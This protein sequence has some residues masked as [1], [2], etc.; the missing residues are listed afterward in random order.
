MPYAF[1]KI[2]PENLVLLQV[3][4]LVSTARRNTFKWIDNPSAP[5][6]EAEDIRKTDVPMEL[7][8]ARV[9]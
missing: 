9:A 3:E 8:D 6:P 4:A 7:F 5:P 1:R 2:G